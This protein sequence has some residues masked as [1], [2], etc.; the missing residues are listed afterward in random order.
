MT[1]NVSGKFLV[2]FPS[3]L[4]RISF[5]LMYNIRIYKI[6]IVFEIDVERIKPC[7]W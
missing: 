7:L 3:S 5:I 4:R 6:K 1:D 2:M